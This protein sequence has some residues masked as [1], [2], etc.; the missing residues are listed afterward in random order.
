M[1]GQLS[2]SFDTVTGRERSLG[3]ATG[4]DRLFGTATFVWDGYGTGLGTVMGREHGDS[5]GTGTLHLRQ[6]ERNIRLGRPWDGDFVLA[7]PR[8]GNVRTASGR[9]LSWDGNVRLGWPRDGH[10]G[11]TDSFFIYHQEMNYV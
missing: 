4:R 10:T 3:T 6:P 8:D 11:G 2:C 1:S 5:H 7:R 9:E